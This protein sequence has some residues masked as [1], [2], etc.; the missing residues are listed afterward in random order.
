MIPVPTTHV[1]TDI[2]RDIYYM[3]DHTV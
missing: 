2:G 3:E 1:C